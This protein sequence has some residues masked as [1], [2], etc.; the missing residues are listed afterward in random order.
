[1]PAQPPTSAGC[2]SAGLRGEAAFL[3]VGPPHADVSVCVGGEKGDLLLSPS[4][5]LF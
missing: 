2:G 5:V 3:E 4:Y 1:M